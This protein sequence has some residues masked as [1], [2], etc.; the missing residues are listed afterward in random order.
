MGLL[1]IENEDNKDVYAPIASIFD[2]NHGLAFLKPLQPVHLFGISL[3]I[4]S[5][6]TKETKGKRIVKER[7]GN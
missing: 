2:S 6:C 1:K 7:K 4:L 3:V 5:N